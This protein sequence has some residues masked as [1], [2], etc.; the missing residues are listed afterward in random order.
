MRFSKTI[1]FLALLQTV[2]SHTV[3]TTLFVDD[4]DQGDGT[5]VRMN[6]TPQNCTFP[7][8]DLASNDMSCGYGG[9][10]GVERVCSAAQASEL[11]FVWREYADASQPGAIDP[12]HKGPCAVYMKAVDSAISDVGYG[13]GWFKIW[14]SGYDTDTKQWCTEKLIANNGLLSVDIPADLKGGSYL[15]RPELLAL[16]QADKTPPNPQFYTGCAQIFLQSQGTGVPSDTVSIP[17][18]VNATDPSVTFDIYNPVWP[19]PMLGPPP[20]IGRSNKKVKAVTAATQQTEGKI[21]GNCVLM[22]ANW[23]GIELDSYTTE[24][25]C[26]NASTA[27]WNQATSCYNTAPPTGSKNCPIWETKCKGI[28]TACNAGNFNGPPNEGANLNPTTASASPV[29]QKNSYTSSAAS[30]TPPTMSS[31]PVVP[32]SSDEMTKNAKCGVETGQTCK[33]YANGPCCS[34][35]G[36]CGFTP[37]YCGEG[38][39]S[40]YGTC[41]PS[42]QPSSEVPTRR[43]TRA[44]GTAPDTTLRMVRAVRTDAPAPNLSKDYVARQ[45]IIIITPSEDGTCGYT[46]A[47]H[48]HTCSGMPSGQCCSEYGWCGHTDPY[49]YDGCQVEF[50]VCLSFGIY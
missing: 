15:V 26:W 5:C 8:N 32:T 44:S 49:C 13:S 36:W 28:Q 27:C 30:S 24:A 4:V 21:P 33:G 22:N 37:A 41:S 46:D 45:E 14:D 18:Y 16:H 35:H 19:Y 31:S 29:T 47:S 40:E 10:L 23:C 2:V 48:G 1:I 12:S 42:I 17:G 50:G 39:Q 34:Q 25:G 9:S 43:D 11:T 3:F 38:C 7:V 6:M 20:Y